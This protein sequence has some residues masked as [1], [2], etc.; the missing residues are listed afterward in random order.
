M[1]LNIRNQG[2]VESDRSCE[3]ST[4]LC[5]WSGGYY[6]VNDNRCIS[7]TYVGLDLA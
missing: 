7:S 4:L 2:N 5:R 1:N 3:L 6:D